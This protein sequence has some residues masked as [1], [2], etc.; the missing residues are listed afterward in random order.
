MTNR[1]YVVTPEVFDRLWEAQNPRP[2]VI[3]VQCHASVRGGRRCSRV[4][5]EVGGYCGQHI[6]VLFQQFEAP[7]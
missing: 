3:D 6:R 2:E 1:A 5:T 7:R 4:A